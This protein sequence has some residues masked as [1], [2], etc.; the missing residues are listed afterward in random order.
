MGVTDGDGQRIGGIGPDNLHAGQ[1]ERNHVTH[2]FL[3]GMAD[4][5]NSLLD[6]IRGVFGHGHSRLR[7]NQQ[8]DGAGMGKL[9]RT[10]RILVDEG[11]LDRRNVWAG[12]IDHLYQRAAQGNEAG[13]KVF[14]LRLYGAMGDMGKAR[15]TQ[16]NH[17]PSGA[18]EAGVDTDNAQVSY[19]AMAL[20]RS[21]NERKQEVYDTKTHTDV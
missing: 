8:S 19:H 13:G 14:A 3:I 10:D 11:M 6:R 12:I 1:Q 21:M 5:D 17:P 4:A 15:S 7:R 2:L 18:D 9:E 16:I 20:A